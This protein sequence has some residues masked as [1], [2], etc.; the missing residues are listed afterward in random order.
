MGLKIVYQKPAN[1]SL[2][3]KVQLAGQKNNIHIQK[4]FPNFYKAI[5]DF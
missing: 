4:K 2:V 3:P 5:N 1:F